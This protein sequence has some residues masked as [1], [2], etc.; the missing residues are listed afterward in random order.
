MSKKSLFAVLAIGV[1]LLLLSLSSLVYSQSS[2]LDS[3]WPARP[4]GKK[5]RV[6]IKPVEKERE[7]FDGDLVSDTHAAIY[8]QTGVGL[9][10]CHSDG[11]WVA[12]G[13]D[14]SSGDPVLARSSGMA[15]TE[16]GIA[17][18]TPCQ[19]EGGQTLLADQPDS[20]YSAS[21]FI[22]VLQP[23]IRYPGGRGS[24]RIKWVQSKP[25]DFR[26][27]GFDEV[28]CFGPAPCPTEIP[29]F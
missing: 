28:Q 9:P 4:A 11:L 14:P 2:E 18:N 12:Y 23:T 21:Y 27:A 17:D 16:G 19:S 7:D 29:E 10:N 26:G 5:F 24:P 22:Q 1:T 25:I 6:W 3:R 15:A 8:W 20:G 13:F